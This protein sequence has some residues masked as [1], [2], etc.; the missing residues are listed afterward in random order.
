MS[1][2]S[3]IRE[4][5][6]T[7]EGILR[8][9]PCWV[10]RSFAIP[11]GR[12]KLDPQDL[13]ALGAHRGGIV[14]RWLASTTPADN[15]PGTSDEE[16]LSYL[17]SDGKRIPLGEAM[18]TL[19][20]EFLGAE[21]M[22][23]QG[24]WNVLCKLSDSA[25]PFPFHLHQDAQYA[26]RV[27]RKPKPEASYYPAQLNLNPGS[28]PYAFMGLNPATETE[29]IRRCL[30]RW[31]EGDNGILYHS[32]AYKLQAG[33]CWQID[34]GVLHAP[35]TLVAYKP[36]A[37]SDVSATFQS[38]VDGRAMPRDLLVKD[39]PVD[40]REDLDY[41]SGMIDWEAN[42]DPDLVRKRR[43]LPR[44][45]QLEDLMA[46]CGY[47]EKW[48]SYSSPD[49]SA[50]ELTVLPGRAAFI[51]DAAA[52]GV[53]VVEGWGTVGRLEVETPVLIRH[54]QAAKDELFVTAGAAK[55]GVVVRNRSDRENLVMLKHF[56]PGNPDVEELTAK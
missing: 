6:A 13:Y 49:Y 41:I 23:E 16:G 36:Q 48:I 54:G 12:L 38:M 39:V 25:G 42:L 19:G 14:E 53:L 11:G 17:I 40:L 24:G 28:F 35:G 37:N 43:F 32:Q 52:Y 5:L 22:R 26:S 55:A 34:A 4:A 51:R 31:N 46:D 56:G 30:T 3:L 29:D 27:G 45:V 50:K 21:T 15:G 10:P 18:E 47:C 1:N 7:G 44:P 2:T 9:A 33:T 8:L 20:D